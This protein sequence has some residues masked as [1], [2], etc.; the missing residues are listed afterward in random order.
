MNGFRILLLLGSASAALA[1]Q[2]SELIGNIDFYGYG[3]ADVA[4]LRDSLPF[5]VGDRVPAQR[6]GETLEALRKMTGREV[7]I[8][9]VCCLQNGRSLVYIGVAEDDAPP[10]R[11][12]PRPNGD[13]K[14]PAEAV[15]ILADLEEHFSA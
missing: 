13:V 15:K 6:D 5:H 4:K 12:N 14:L 11:F 7:K 8:E 10:I 3:K 2:P 1:Q 9:L